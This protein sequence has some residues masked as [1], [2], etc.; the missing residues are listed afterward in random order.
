VLA[1]SDIFLFEGFRLDRRDG[2]LFRQDERGV[3]VP[4]AIGGRALDVLGVLIE[5][6][7]VLVSKDEI[8]KA[9]WARTAVEN[10]NLTIQIS[11][12][13][14]VLDQARPDG[15]CIQTVAAQGY[16]FVAPVTRV[17]QPAGSKAVAPADILAVNSSSATAGRRRIVLAGLAATIAALL[18]PLIAWFVRPA[19]ITSPALLAADAP[20]SSSAS[21]PRLSI[22]V[23]PFANLSDDPG[24]QYIAD[25]I[26]D[27][28]T[29]DLSRLPNMLVIA[30]NTA[31][32]YKGKSVDAKQIGRELG[33]RYLLEG[34]VQRSANQLRVNT[35][36][37]DGEA[38]SHLWAERFDRAVGD[39]FALQN[40][41]TSRIAATLD[42][43]LVAA[44]AARLTDKPDALEYVLRGRAVMTR[45][46]PTRESYADAIGFFEKALA[47]DPNSIDPQRWLALALTSRML[48][49]LSAAP[50]E[51]FRRAEAVLASALG[52]APR[53]PLLHYVKGQILRAVAQGLAPPFRLSAEAR[54]AGF[55]DAIPE[56]ETMLAAN[57][58]D[59]RGLANLAWCKFMTGA[60]EEAIPLFE[61]VIR[62][63]PREP[64]LYLQYFR[65]GIV[66]FF[67]GR[68][69]EAILW[70]EKARRANP[71]FA[72]AHS[73][74][75]AALGVKG[76]AVRAA[77]ELAEYYEAAKG[78]AD[79]RFATIALVRKNGDLNTPALHDR[80]EEFL[81]AGLRKAGLPE[82]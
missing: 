75:A 78:H 14:R 27:D 29:T 63:S 13:R 39:L 56:Y 31:F 35:Q 70:L 76:D 58:N 43:E 3:F 15:S 28:L 10:A 65:L 20:I 34:S 47:F 30:R 1:T 41:I 53:D 73:L 9:V 44:E 8:M 51:D 69:D 42:L 71:R 26:T 49:G 82:E 74:L 60:E 19:P 66:H 54:V 57:P 24:Q 33:V 62:L 59:V 77:A 18:A 36:L 11:A 25:G 23:L 4:V 81:I 38:G 68:L 52:A 12:L 46:P 7:G 37:I 2:G 61:K 40:D 79:S 21:V 55:A 50:A 17:E 5:R 16:R 48:D 45:G 72:V 80:F 22:V 64:S 32:T 67:R 6:P